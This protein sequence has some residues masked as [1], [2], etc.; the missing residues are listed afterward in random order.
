MT[1]HN[2]TYHSPQTTPLYGIASHLF[3]AHI[4][5]RPIAVVSFRLVM[6]ADGVVVWCC[7][8]IVSS[9]IICDVV[10]CNVVWCRLAIVSSCTICDGVLRS[11]VSCLVSS[12][13][14]VSRFVSFQCYLS[15]FVVLP[16]LV[17]QRCDA[18][19]CGGTRPYHTTPYHAMP[20]HKPHHT[21][22]E[23]R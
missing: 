10:L 21:T 23:M 17:P 3:S 8:A 1:Q 22:L 5:I 18:V 13:W 11:G 7:L 6:L 16:I 20:C 9:C 19:R 15:R 2:R 12:Q 4:G 14:H